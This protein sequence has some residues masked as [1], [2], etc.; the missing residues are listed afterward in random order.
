M[1]INTR[2]VM[3]EMNEWFADDPINSRD[4]NLGIEDDGDYDDCKCLGKYTAS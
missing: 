4:N 2:L 1:T 3:E